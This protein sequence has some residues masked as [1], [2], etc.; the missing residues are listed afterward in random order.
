MC[1]ERKIPE[2]LICS[3][4]DAVTEEDAEK[5]YELRKHYKRVFR[6]GEPK[7]C[8]FKYIAFAINNANLSDAFFRKSLQKSMAKSCDIVIVCGDVITPN[9]KEQIEEA[10]QYHKKIYRMIEKVH[11]NH[12]FGNEIL[13]YIVT[14]IMTL[15]CAIIFSCVVKYLLEKMMQKKL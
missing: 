7:C 1:K 6:R 13:S 9:M 5:E 15:A 8:T 2:I 3:P 12:L 4:C 11:M 10:K 14:V